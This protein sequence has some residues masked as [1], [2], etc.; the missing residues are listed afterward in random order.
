MAMTRYI[1]GSISPQAVLQVG[2]RGW[3]PAAS[4]RSSTGEG[5]GDL[6]R[7][8]RSSPTSETDRKTEEGRAMSQHSSQ[9][10]EGRKE[11]RKEAEIVVE[12]GL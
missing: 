4:S 3:T 10:V 5:F 8:T 9:N 12:A 7:G 1:L 2:G 6:A 11:G